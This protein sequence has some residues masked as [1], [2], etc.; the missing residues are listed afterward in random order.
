MSDEIPSL[1]SAPATNQTPQEP[2]LRSWREVAHYLHRGV[3]TVQRWEKALHL[4]VHRV[5]TGSEI[6]AFTAE[7][8]AWFL[9][10]ARNSSAPAD[11]ESKNWREIAEQAAVEEDPEKLMQL[12]TELNRLLV[13]E[14]HKAERKPAPKLSAPPP[15]HG[16]SAA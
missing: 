6:F 3:R 2:I 5:T 7:V 12:V 1:A 16:N 9:S 8:D 15:G 14:E 11:G 10:V 4:P 13:R